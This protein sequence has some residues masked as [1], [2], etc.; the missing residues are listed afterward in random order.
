M[1]SIRI[2]KASVFSL[3]EEIKNRIEKD[4]IKSVIFDPPFILIFQENDCVLTVKQ[5]GGIS[6][7]GR[8]IQP[9]L[10]YTLN[11]QYNLLIRGEGKGKL[12]FSIFN[13][14]WINAPKIKNTLELSDKRSIYCLHHPSDLFVMYIS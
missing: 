12:C 6:K 11:K 8:T 4:G 1:Q 7:L 9:T 13:D 2:D 5:D 14:Q 3:N 10:F